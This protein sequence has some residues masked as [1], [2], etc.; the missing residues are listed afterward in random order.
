MSVEPFDP[1]ALTLKLD[2]EVLEEFLRAARDL[3][4][5]DFGLDRD[6]VSALSA[7]A[8]QDSANLRRCLA[9]GCEKR[10]SRPG[11]R[12]RRDNSTGRRKALPHPYTD[13]L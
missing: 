12:V 10:A 13:S 7:L 4:A 3:D 11:I 6:R 8:R 9:I 2:G 1:G 5:P